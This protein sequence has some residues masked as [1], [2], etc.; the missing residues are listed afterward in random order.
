M[1]PRRVA[2][3]ERR[4]ATLTLLA[5]LAAATLLALAPPAAYPIPNCPFNSLT[6]G[7]CPGCGTL[8][9]THSLLGGH[10]LHAVG[11]NL[12]FVIALPFFAWWGL[13]LASAAV[14]GK[15]WGDVSSPVFGWAALTAIVA[16]WVIRNLPWAAFAV[17]R[18][19][20]ANPLLG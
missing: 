1:E 6:G 13:G 12:L 17:L 4:V 3:A 18:P 9:A 2:P 11:Y 19:T 10:F 16:W 14:A 5:G 7:Y 8:R 15:R 20:A